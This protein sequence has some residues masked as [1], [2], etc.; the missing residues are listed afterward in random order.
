MEFEEF[1]VYENGHVVMYSKYYLMIVCV[2]YFTNPSQT[3]SLFEI[4][5]DN[6]IMSISG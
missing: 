3:M 4:K 2:V 1:T 5:C 6:V